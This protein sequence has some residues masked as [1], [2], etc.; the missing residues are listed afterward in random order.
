MLRYLQRENMVKLARGAVEI[1]DRTGL[2]ALS[3]G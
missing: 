3:G 1:T 2:E